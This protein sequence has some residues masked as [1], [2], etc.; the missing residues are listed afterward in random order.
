MA[1]IGHSVTNRTWRGTLKPAIGPAAVIDQLLLAGIVAV[2]Q[3]YERGGN[4]DV[5]DVRDPD[6]LRHLHRR[7]GGR[8][9]LDLHRGDV[10]APDLEHVLPAPGEL[11]P[12]VGVEA[13]EVARREP[14][15]P[16]R[17]LG[18]HRVAVVALRARSA[19]QHQRADLPGREVLPG[20]SIDDLH[21]GT[22]ERRTARGHACLERIVEPA[23][24]DDPAALGD[25]VGGND[26][27]LR[28]VRVLEL[29]QRRRSA[30]R[31]HPADAG[32]V[33]GGECG[34]MDEVLHERGKRRVR[35]RATLLHHQ[36]QPLRRVPVELA[37]VRRADRPVGD[38]Q[39][40][41]CQVVKRKWVPEA[42]LA[43]QLEP[44]DDRERSANHRLVAEW[45]ALRRRRGSRGVHHQE[46]LTEPDDPAGRVDLTV[47][48][49]GRRG[50]ERRLVDVAR[51]RRAAED[52]TQTEVGQ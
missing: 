20:L 39:Q 15:R 41:P 13:R 10:L 45:A 44:V 46:L 8:A 37:D 2:D 3:L 7:V 18:R 11:D 47:R 16:P 43:G 28:E 4:L 50:V 51:S 1:D 32:E 27:R 40:Q 24:T 23:V 6:D 9:G 5:A 31:E 30:E 12:P 38:Q 21:L 49:A 26:D 34:V 35:E 25:P 22:A 52:D 17:L 14:A 36:A 19:A 48:H 33:S 42:V 29:A